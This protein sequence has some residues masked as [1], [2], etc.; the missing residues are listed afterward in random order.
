MKLVFM[1]TPEFAVPILNNL[2]KE[3]DVILVVTQPDK[4]VGR[5][6]IMTAPPVKKVAIEA[7]I[8]VF[9]PT[10]LRDDYQKIIDLKPDYIITAA[11]G[12][13]LPKRLIETIHAINVH[14]SILPSYR[15]G[16][17]IQ[18]AIMNL[19]NRTGITIMKMEYKMD[20]GD[21]YY[22][23]SLPISP[24]D[25]TTTLTN[26]LSLL[27]ADMIIHYLKNMKLYPPIKQDEDE[28][29]FAY[30][31]TFEDQ[32]INWDQSEEF[33]NAHVRAMLNDPGAV[34]YYNNHIFKI[35]ETKKSDI[36]TNEAP[37][38]IIS[39]DK[40]IAVSCING[41]IEIEKLQLSG[42]KMMSAKEFLN[43]Q[44]IL[45]VGTTFGKEENYE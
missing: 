29:S 45:K 33:I 39:L 6:R 32:I 18:K 31:I 43:G 21:I 7:N 4:P 35:Y 41:A 28:V 44:T 3:F 30:N 11:Y 27:G 5:K 15:G 2:I 10:K 12:Q 13:M 17:P 20:S 37:G 36:I 34:T 25:T 23:E 19:D 42:K 38:T 9:Q 1:G 40:K 14:G 16:A 26:K 8:P 24:N 22:Q